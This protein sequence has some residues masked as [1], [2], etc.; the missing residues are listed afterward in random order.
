MLDFDEHR[1]EVYNTFLS[2]VLQ[3][4]FQQTVLSK[5]EFFS[6]S[7]PERELIIRELRDI[8]RTPRQG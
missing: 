1:Y 2:I 7:R 6:L 5:E 3:A 8:A 4:G